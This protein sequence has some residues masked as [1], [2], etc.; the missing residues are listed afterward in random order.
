MSDSTRPNAPLSFLRTL[1]AQLLEQRFLTSTLHEGPGEDPAVLTVNDPQGQPFARIT[2]DHPRY[3]LERLD[4]GQ[5]GQV[6]TLEPAVVQPFLTDLIDQRPRP[7]FRDFMVDLETLGTSAHSLVWSIGVVPFS[8]EQG[9]LRIGE[10]LEI[11][12][13]PKLAQASGARI[14]PATVGFW[15][16]QSREAQ[17]RYHASLKSPHSEPAALALLKRFMTH[18]GGKDSRLWQPWGN[19]ALFDI[20]MLEQLCERNALKIPWHFVRPRCY[21]TVTQIAEANGWDDTTTVNQGEQHNALDDALTQVHRLHSACTHLGL[22]NLYTPSRAERTALN[23][24]PS[25]T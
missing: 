7:E 19:G 22:Q 2:E 18:W 20:G 23:T 9:Q 17:E 15:M 12:I 24:E 4:E 8:I 11:L 13:N 25:G 21:R 5:P 3:A 16:R 6:T 10:G 1:Q 14:D